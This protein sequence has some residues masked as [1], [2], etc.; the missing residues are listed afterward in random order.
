[1]KHP[2]NQLHA[3]ISL[4]SKQDCAGSR[5]SPISIPEALDHVVIYHSRG[6][7]EGVADSRAYEVETAL[8]QVFA[9]GI[10]FRR[11]GWKPRPQPPGVHSRFAANKLPDVAIERA[12]LLL[13]CQERLRIPYRR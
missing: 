7:H 8:L 11:Q 6:L 2:L 3:D 13:N 1:M 5:L 4:A 12:E 10:G 9:H